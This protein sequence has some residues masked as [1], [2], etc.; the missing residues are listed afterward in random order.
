MKQ[1]L[2]NRVVRYAQ[3]IILGLTLGYC[4]LTICSFMESYT[5]L[6][7]L[8]VALPLF[9]V[10]WGFGLFLSLVHEAGHLVGGLLSGRRMYYVSVAGHCLM[11]RPD[12]RFRRGYAATPGVGGVCSTVSEGSPQPFRLYLLLGPL[13]TLLVGGLCAYLA[14]LSDPAW[15]LPW[16]V[17]LRRA[18]LHI[19]MVLMAVQGVVG[20]IVN[21][22]PMHISGGISDGMQL[23]SLSFNRQSRADWEQCNR[24]A[25]LT[26]Q[27]LT[28]S[29]MP[30]ELF[31]PLPPER[32]TS[33]YARELTLY[34]L[35][36]L[37]ELGDFAA[38]IS[39]C[40]ELTEAELPLSPLE[41]LC[42]TRTGA[43]C[44]AL[45]DGPGPFC[46]RMAEQDM[47]RLMRFTRKTIGTQLT[48]YAMAKLVDR[49]EALAA[50]HL[51]DFTRSVA[52][53]PFL[54]SARLDGSLITLIDAKAK[55]TP[56]V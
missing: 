46:Q 7:F 23:L 48:Q 25:Y 54:E 39:L 10:A 38:A 33:P 51:A 2:L 26:W 52:R 15:E 30:E 27:G 47:Q 8:L 9:P 24:I 55:E 43:V 22:I 20:C 56:H 13:S 1:P 34:R 45:T 11:R 31:A 35:E 16:E 18:I 19:P 17:A 28:P 53:S 4:A 37:T 6:T 42:I 29:E 44:E 50:R 5:R 21:L 14:T 41:R 32:L 12:G 3:E 36:R 40:H 49:D